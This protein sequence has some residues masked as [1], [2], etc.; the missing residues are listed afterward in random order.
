MSAVASS[1]FCWFCATAP[2]AHP[3]FRLQRDLQINYRF[4]RLISKRLSPGSSDRR[5]RDS[6]VSVDQSTGLHQEALRPT[7]DVP[8]KT[9]SQES[10]DLAPTIGTPTGS[11]RDS[12]TLSRRT[13]VGPKALWGRT[14]GAGGDQLDFLTRAGGHSAFP[15]LLSLWGF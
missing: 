11:V 14:K 5:Q 4:L 9:P 6:S 2:Q 3:V 8:S 15:I 7:S 12:R 1:H 13:L 10:Q